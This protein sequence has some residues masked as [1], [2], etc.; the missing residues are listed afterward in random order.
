M[1]IY[2]A[3]KRNTFA[4]ML[5]QTIVKWI[6]PKGAIFLRNF[7]E[8]SLT[9]NLM[10]QLLVDMCKTTQH[11]IRQSK[12]AS[13]QELE[14]VNDELTHTV[15]NDLC[16]I[17]LTPIARE[18]IYELAG[19]MDDVADLI[20]AASR[21]ILP[22]KM[23]NLRI[24]ELHLSQCLL[25]MTEIIVKM[26]E[27]LQ[28]GD[29]D[30]ALKEIDKIRMLERE[31]DDLYDQGMKYLYDNEPHFKDF[32]RSREVLMSLEKTADA[33]GEVANSIDNIIWKRIA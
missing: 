14:L 28:K 10:A 23:E 18:D 32:I 2:L 5:V 3:F 25:R 27:A 30:N 29:F 19:Q 9:I 1:A 24:H 12:A 8:G 13:I 20:F 6:K 22:I 21:S 17:Y 4:A 31:A 11:D 26:T 7:H 16:R 15:F 33:C